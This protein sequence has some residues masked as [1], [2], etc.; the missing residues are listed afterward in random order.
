MR[1]V[2]FNI[3]KCKYCPYMRCVGEKYY[4]N[5]NSVIIFDLC[6]KEHRDIDRDDLEGFPSFCKLKQ[7]AKYKKGFPIMAIENIFQAIED[8]ELIY[9]DSPNWISKIRSPKY[10]VNMPTTH[11]KRMIDNG[12]LYIAIKD[13]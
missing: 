3:E 5:K 2:T 4:V 8:K 1:R 6:I 11:L 10:V 13:E 12:Q 7:V 9:V